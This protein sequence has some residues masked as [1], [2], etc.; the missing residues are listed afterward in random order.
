MNTSNIERYLTSLGK[1]LVKQSRANLTRKKKNVNKALYNSIKFKV[2]SD[3]DG[4]SLKIFMLDY[5]TFVDKGVSGNKKIQE[6]TTY[7][8]RK[9]ESPFK[10]RSKQ[11]PAGILEKWIRARKL[12]GRNSET[13]RFITNKSFAF[14]IARKI[15]LQGIKSTSFFQRPLGL[16]WKTFGAEILKSLEQDIIDTLN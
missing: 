8:G 12:K 6:Y 2:D 1:Y 13:G 10:Y 11:P 15:K 5:G 9:V 7:D 14:L 3:V 16:G 4:Y